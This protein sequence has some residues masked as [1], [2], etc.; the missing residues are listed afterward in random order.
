MPNKNH[1]IYQQWS[2]QGVL[3]RL[4]DAICIVLGVL[5]AVRGRP[6]TAADHYVIAAG[7]AI[8]VYFLLAEVG[9]LYRSWRGV[10]AHREAVGVL[11]CWGCTLLALLALG[12]VSQFTGEF[13]RMLDAGVVRGDAGVDPGQP[14]RHALGAANPPLLGL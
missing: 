10:S 8:I 2:L 9:D 12:F 13:A 6:T 5:I 3:Y 14:D 1:H 7:A 4:F 11:V